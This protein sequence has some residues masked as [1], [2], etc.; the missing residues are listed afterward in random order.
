[1]VARAPATETSPRPTSSSRRSA[2]SWSTATARQG[3]YE[4]GLSVRTTVEP[5]AAGAGRPRAARTASSPTTASSGWRGPWGQLA[6]KAL[7]G[8]WAGGADGH[9]P[10]LRAR[11][12]APRRRAWRRARKAVEIGFD[13]GEPAA[14]WRAERHRLG[15]ARRQ[16]RSRRGDLVAGRAA[17]RQERRQAARCCASGPRSRAPWSRSTRTPAACWR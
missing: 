3:F 11:R 2:A 15:E 17:G 6:D 13:D 16:D 5:D 10:G 7:A 12:L 9:G 1:M 8:G 4:G 14:R